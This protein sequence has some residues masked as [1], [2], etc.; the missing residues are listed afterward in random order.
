M[1]LR[2]RAISGEVFIV[3]ILVAFASLPFGLKAGEYEI[4]TTAGVVA[5]HVTASQYSPFVTVSSGPGS[6]GSHPAGGQAR[7]GHMLEADAV[8]YTWYDHPFVL[9]VVFDR[10]AASL[11]SISSC[12]S[13]LRH[14]PDDTDLDD[15]TAMAALRETFSEVALAALNH[16]V[17]VVRRQARLYRVLDLRRDDIEITVRDLNGTVLCQDP[18]HE[19]LAQEEVELAER[20]ELSQQ[21]S[22]WYQQLV[23]A[24]K[25]PDSVGLAD[26]LMMEAERAYSQRFTRQAITTCHTAVETAASALLRWGMSRRGLGDRVIDHTLATR[27]LTA[28]LDILLQKNTGSSL[29]RTNRPLWK[30]FNMLNDLRN[31]VVHRGK[32]PSPQEAKFAIKSARELLDWMDVLRSR[33][34]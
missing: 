29:K 9:R 30:A 11:G 2:P 26:E 31:E 33:N 16:L 23:A 15:K 22:E 18:L 24:L 34:R 13:I 3:P 7:S 5:A 21:S 12:A 25:A 8:S 4:A 17:A 1:G 32:R 6:Q 14:L 28:K 10:N 27:A 20:S 19:V